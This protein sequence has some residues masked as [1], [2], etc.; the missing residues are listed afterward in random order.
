M[1]FSRSEYLSQSNSGEFTDAAKDFWVGARQFNIWW[2]LATSEVLQRFGRTYLGI[3]WVLVSFAAIMTVK[4]I[5]L[6]GLQTASA[7]E[8]A[9]FLGIGYSIWQFMARS[10][11]DGCTCYVRSKGWLLASRFP[12]SVYIMQSVAVAG[13][14]NAITIL[15]VICIVLLFWEPAQSQVSLLVIPGLVMLMINAVAVMMYLG[16]LSTRYRDLT[17]FVSAGV[18]VLFFATPIIW[19]PGALDVPQYLI[20]WNPFARFIEIVREPLLYGTPG[21]DNWLFVSVFTVI[22]LLVAKLVYVRARYRQI[23]WL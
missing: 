7:I 11:N 23:H 1:S 13:I 21:L 9:V 8:F 18:R 12:H 14:E 10:L 3:F 4:I 15:P 6:G 17:Q 5:F 20:D 22:H 19:M 2:A 16:P